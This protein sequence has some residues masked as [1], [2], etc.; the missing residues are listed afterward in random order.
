MNHCI[1]I[2]RKKLRHKMATVFGD[3]IHILSLDLQEMLFDDLVTAFENRV[4]VLK[5]VQ[6]DVPI[7]LVKSVDYATVKA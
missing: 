4:N 1:L 2:D 5:W 3:N 7:E 6:S